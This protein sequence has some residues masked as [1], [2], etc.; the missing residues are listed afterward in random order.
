M[1]SAAVSFCLTVL[2]FKTGALPILGFN[3]VVFHF[4]VS[5]ASFASCPLF[6][7]ATNAHQQRAHF[8]N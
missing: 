5:V 7:Y 6:S 8:H 2:P 4:Q 1:R 3:N